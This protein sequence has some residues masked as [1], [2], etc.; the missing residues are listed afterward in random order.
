MG[1]VFEDVLKKNVQKDRLLPVYILFGDDS[2]LKK[3][4]SDKISKFSAK[5]DDFFNYQKFE[6][7]C[8]LQ[9]VYDF[10]MQ[11][12]MMADK[13]YCEICDFDFEHCGKADFDKLCVLL[14]EVP[15]S[16]SLVLRFDGFD[17][18]SKKSAKF[19]KLISAAEKNNGIAVSLNH[20]RVPE[21]VKMLHDGAAKRGANLDTSVAKYLVEIAGEDINLLQNELMK[22][23]AF[24]GSEPITKETV[25]LVCVKTVEAS[26]F[27]LSTH[28]INCNTSDALLCLDEL[29]FMKIEPIMILYTVSASFVDMF[30]VFA[31]KDNG[32]TVKE[33]A[34]IF[35]Y[36]KRAFVLDKL[37]GSLKKFDSKKFNLCFKALVDADRGLKSFG[38]DPRTVLEKMILRLCFIISKG[39]DID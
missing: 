25:D 10:V 23:C 7:N 37:S 17:F 33:V 5:P 4:Y 14:S 18:D 16:C 11:I 19:K 15:E 20:R 2:Y 3:H 6:N 34:D 13:K 1:I 38:K 28:I 9:E 36:N 22:L 31:A 21:L 29:F 35:A 32:H 30:R 27:N 12:P 26:V 24:A 8:D 39:E